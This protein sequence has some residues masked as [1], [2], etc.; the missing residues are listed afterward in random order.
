MVTRRRVALP[1]HIGA[2]SGAKL[3]PVVDLVFEVNSNQL[4]D[5]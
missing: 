5:Y 2:N 4:V 1:C 3:A